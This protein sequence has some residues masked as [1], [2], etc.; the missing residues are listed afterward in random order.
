MFGVDVGGW[1]TCRKD[2]LVDLH[3][4]CVILLNNVSR[5]LVYNCQFYWF[6]WPQADRLPW[7][8][9]LMQ[10]SLS[11]VVCTILNTHRNALYSI[12]STFRWFMVGLLIL[13]WNLLLRLSDHV[14]TI[15]WLKRSSRIKIQKKQSSLH[16]VR[17]QHCQ[18]VIFFLEQVDRSW[19]YCYVWAYSSQKSIIQS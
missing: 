1:I 7:S 4:T 12:F 14:A 13:K 5:Q 18:L 15:S 17:I 19:L 9:C 3:F 2:C 16:Q 6:W 10:A 11:F 8:R